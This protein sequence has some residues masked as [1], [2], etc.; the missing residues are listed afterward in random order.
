[1]HIETELN[2]TYVIRLSHAEAL[3]ARRNP[4]NFVKLLDDVL[5]VE[6]PLKT[7]RKHKP[8][9]SSK[10]P[11]AAVKGRPRQ[12]ARKSAAA[13]KCQHCPRTFARQGNRDNHERNCPSN[14]EIGAFQPD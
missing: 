7:V 6:A 12:P 13:F 9:S 14:V 11:R 10:L 3:D 1:M 4:K 8:S 5:P 2:P